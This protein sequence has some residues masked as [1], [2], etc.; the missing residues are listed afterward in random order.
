MQAKFT[1]IGADGV[2]RMAI[3]PENMKVDPRAERLYDVLI[4]LSAGKGGVFVTYC[5][6]EGQDYVITT[7]SKDIHQDI[8]RMPDSTRG[9]I[10]HLLNEELEAL[11]R[12]DLVFL[13]P[14]QNPEVKQPALHVTRA[15]QSGLIFL[16]LA[17]AA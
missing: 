10:C 12:P 7:T 9:I 5:S 8:G 15:E 2:A 1:T 3:T 14:V 4:A 6:H 13:S 17:R 16:S 11:E